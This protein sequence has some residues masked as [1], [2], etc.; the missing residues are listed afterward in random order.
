M[1]TTFRIVLYAADQADA[2]RAFTRAFQR[3]AALDEA[4]SDYRDS[5]E[6]SRITREAVD[7]AVPISDD[8]LAVL[9]A[10]DTLGRQSDGA[11]DITIGALSRLWRRA[12]R[13][14]ELP[15]SDDLRSALAVTGYQLITLD[16]AH[17]TVRFMR[18]GIRLD[19][20]GIAKGYAADRALEEIARTGRRRALVAAGGDLAIGDPP[21]GRPGWEV[22][23]AG[24][25]PDRAAPASPVVVARCG[26]ST[27][28]DAEQ[29]VAIDG[30]RYSHIIDPR[31]GVALKGHRSVSVIARDATS[32]DMLATALSVLNPGEGARVIAQYRGA[33]ALV[34]IRSPDGDHWTRTRSW[35]RVVSP[36]VRRSQ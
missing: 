4:L 14:L 35:R 13:Q 6:L 32:S 36:A 11:F 27:S 1:G 15:S 29:W 24:L 7:R 8:L 10:A 28:G 30:V 20:G 33:A 31:T 9:S 25:D 26:I 12:R 22:A 5:S 3:I 19:A 2:D 18:A 16:R 21:P 34:G 17:K 23:L